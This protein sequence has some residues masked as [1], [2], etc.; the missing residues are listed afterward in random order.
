MINKYV[1]LVQFFLWVFYQRLHRNICL[2]EVVEN[3]F[4]LKFVIIHPPAF[5][6]LVIIVEK[7]LKRYFTIFKWCGKTKHFNIAE[8]TSHAEFNLSKDNL[9]SSCVNDL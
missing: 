9:S 6:T 1:G 4:A 5:H 8:P 3:I 2:L 7:L